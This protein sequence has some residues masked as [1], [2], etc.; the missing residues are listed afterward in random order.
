M[1]DYEQV[2]ALVSVNSSKVMDVSGASLED[3]APVIQ[4]TFQNSLNQLWYFKTL[5]QV[6]GQEAYQIVNKNS[7]KVLGVS[8]G[9]P[10]AGAP[11][12]NEA[13]LTSITLLLL[14]E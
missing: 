11:S 1:P 3:G 7:G 8:G 12:S 14:T 13:P 6:N 2:Y 4:N 9:S 5:G 10:D